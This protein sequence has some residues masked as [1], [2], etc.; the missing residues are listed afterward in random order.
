MPGIIREAQIYQGGKMSNL[1]QRTEIQFNGANASDV[2][3]FA[4]TAGGH[5]FDG[6]LILVYENGSRIMMKLGD[7]LFKDWEGKVV[8]GNPA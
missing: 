3:R 2:S 7:Y 8:S 6:E 1:D 4:G 5:I